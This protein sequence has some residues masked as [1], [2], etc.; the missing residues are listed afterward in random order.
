MA[1]RVEDSSVNAVENDGQSFDQRSSTADDYLQSLA[2]DKTSLEFYAISTAL[3]LNHQHVEFLKLESKNEEQM[4]DAFWT[5]YI[6]GAGATTGFLTLAAAGTFIVANAPTLAI[7]TASTSVISL[8]VGALAQHESKQQASTIESL[9]ERIPEKIKKMEIAAKE[10]KLLTKLSVQ[11]RKRIVE[12]T[13][14]YLNKGQL[15]LNNSARNLGYFYLIKNI[16]NS[17]N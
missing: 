8:A 2:T 17:L 5:K 9:G 7:I 11:E 6:T 12:A 16:K 14:K 13:E 4:V 10:M 15:S 1:C 3:W